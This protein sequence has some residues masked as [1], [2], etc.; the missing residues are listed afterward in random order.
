MNRS[1]VLMVLAEPP[2]YPDREAAT[3]PLV[4]C[5]STR[6]SG[7]A[8]R[9]GDTSRLTATR[10][11]MNCWVRAPSKWRP[12]K[13]APPS[14]VSKQSGFSLRTAAATFRSICCSQRL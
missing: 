2:G 13:S 6:Y 11:G 10:R 14:V 5:H 1:V 3:G 8:I 7:T 9:I 12:K 4:T